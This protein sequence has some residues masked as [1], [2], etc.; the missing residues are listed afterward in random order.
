[1]VEIMEGISA[2]GTLHDMESLPDDL[3][4]TFVTAHEV[5]FEWHVRMQAAFQKHTDNGVSKT[6]NLPNNAASDD[7]ERAYGLAYE[8]GCLGITVFR[9][10]C[11]GAQV[12]N[13]GT[14]DMA[15]SGP[16]QTMLPGLATIR[17]RPRMVRGATHRVETPVG[18]AFITVNCDDKGEPLE[19]F[20]NIGRAGSDVLAMAESMG[21]MVSLVLRTPSPLSQREK[22]EQLVDQLRGIAGSRSLGFGANRVL[23]LPDAIGQ[24]LGQYLE[25]A[26]EAGLDAG[27]TGTIGLLSV[28]SLPVALAVG[29]LCPKCGVAAYVREEGCKKCHSCG[30]SEC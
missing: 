9:D 20:I 13:V 29:D 16:A 17:P 10:G 21:R 11:K 4:R 2:R 19:L 18:T 23:S 7:I 15:V 3:K 8:L 1:T 27:Q 12:L 24:I 5:D 25:E 22:V 30:Y 14:S 6:I 26:M 28:D